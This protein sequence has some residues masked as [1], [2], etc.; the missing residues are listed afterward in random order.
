MS[1]DVVPFPKRFTPRDICREMA[2]TVHCSDPDKL[3]ELLHAKGWGDDPEAPRLLA[4]A[5]EAFGWTP[6]A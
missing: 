5:K 6:A 3:A 1:G 2:H 4:I